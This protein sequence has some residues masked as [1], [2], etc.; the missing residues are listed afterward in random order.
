LTWLRR[1]LTDTLRLGVIA[2]A[3]PAV[4]FLTSRFADS[5]PAA[6]I[7]IQSMTSRAIQKALDAFEIDGGVTY[8]DNEPLENVRRVPLYRER[9]VFDLSAARKPQ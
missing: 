6:N 3:M 8:L 1:G 2:A 9:H 4:A 7:E 5:R